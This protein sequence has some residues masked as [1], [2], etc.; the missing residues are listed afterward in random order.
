MQRVIKVSEAI[1]DTNL[2]A[3]NELFWL[4]LIHEKVKEETDIEV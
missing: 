4:G 3:E 2:S 1:N